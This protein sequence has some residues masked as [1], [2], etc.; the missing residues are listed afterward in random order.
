MA[1]RFDSLVVAVNELRAQAMGQAAHKAADST[2]V[3]VFTNTGTVDRAVDVYQDVITKYEAHIASTSFHDAAD[4]TNVVTEIGVPEECYLLLNELK[5]DYNAHRVLVSGSVHAGTDTVNTVTATD[6][7]TRALAIALANNLR[8]AFLVNW[9]NVTSH[10]GGSGDTTNPVTLA[11]LTSVSPW[12]DI[13][14]MA[15]HLRTKYEAHRVLT[16]GSVHGLADS[17]NT[18]TAAAVGTFTTACYA[19]I[20][21]L[22]GDFNAH[23]AEAA[24]SHRIRDESMKVVAANASSAATFMALAAELVTAH[25]DHL[26]SGTDI[27][28][29]I[30]LLSETA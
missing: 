5:V 24:T 16:A 26:S 15:D 19:G 21:E 25:T 4:S 29:A 28:S 23:I 12:V 13:A 20:N 1:D 8:A 18:V 7:T 6:A 22:K 10:H 17:T 11:A 27:S 2:N 30:P 14:A 9:L 3:L